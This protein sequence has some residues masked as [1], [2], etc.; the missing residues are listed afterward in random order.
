M[1]ISVKFCTRSSYAQKELKTLGFLR[2]DRQL[3]QYLKNVRNIQSSKY[4]AAAESKS[5]TA[6]AAASAPAMPQAAAATALQPHPQLW[7]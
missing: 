7:R 2:N 6:A 1:N 3:S 5:T 4:G